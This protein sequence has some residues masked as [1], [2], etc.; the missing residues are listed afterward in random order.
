MYIESWRYDRNTGRLYITPGSSSPEKQRVED[1][2]D[3]KI[4]KDVMPPLPVALFLT[5][6]VVAFLYFT[7]TTNSSYRFPDEAVRQ[8]CD[9]IIEEKAKR[10]LETGIKNQIREW[11]KKTPRHIIPNPAGDNN[12]GRLKDGP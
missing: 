10:E 1:E 8:C 12:S 4:V 9:A 3:R 11:I 2:Y 6:A 5:P 7:I